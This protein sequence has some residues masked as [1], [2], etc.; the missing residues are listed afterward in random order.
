MAIDP[1]DQQ[2]QSNGATGIYLYCFAPATGLPQLKIA[3]VDTGD[4]V[5][6]QIYKDLVAVTS[7]VNVA[8]FS[9][10]AGEVNLKNLEWVGPRAWRHQQVVE[11]AMQHV[12][13]LPVRFGAIF[14]A[15]QPMLAMWARHYRVISEFLR[16]VETKSEW[17]VKGYLDR[18]RA[19]QAFNPD[20]VTG[21]GQRLV[22]VSPGKQYFMQKQMAAEFER[23]LN[24]RLKTILS[25]VYNELTRYTADFREL[26]V[27]SRKSTGLEMD[28]VLN[29]SFLVSRDLQEDFAACLEKTQNAQE[30]NGLRF[31]LSGPWP[32]YSFC[33]SLN[34]T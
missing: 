11:A 14:S 4:M 5:T 19:R 22:H 20:P 2:N 31:D 1:G 17:A 12:P 30:K 27:Q 32:P 23:K 18:Q 29:W 25:A 21:N 16:Q 24:R 33:P 15:L 7:K 13:V 9:G 10:R 6:R 34:M 3:G 26:T 28:M 8:D